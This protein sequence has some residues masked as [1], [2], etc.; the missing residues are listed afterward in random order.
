MNER[1]LLPVLVAASPAR[2][3]VTRFQAAAADMLL[4]LGVPPAGVEAELREMAEVRVGKTMSRQVLGS[5]TDFSYLMDAY[6]NDPMDLEDI[7]MRL[8]DAPCNPLGMKRPADVAVE[9]LGAMR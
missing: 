1:S 8:A 4:R 7:A 3:L 2:S 5:M 6:R 9:V